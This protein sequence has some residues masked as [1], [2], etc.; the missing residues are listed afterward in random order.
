MNDYYSCLLAVP[1]E[2][3]QDFQQAYIDAAHNN[4][5]GVGLEANN[6]GYPYVYLK[7]NGVAI[8]YDQSVAQAAFTAS[9]I[10]PMEVD[11]PD[12]F[13]DTQIKHAGD[14]LY[15]DFTDV[16]KYPQY[17]VS[18]VGELEY[19]TMG[20]SREIDKEDKSKYIDL[21]HNATTFCTPGPDSLGYSMIQMDEV[22][23]NN[24]EGLIVSEVNRFNDEYGNVIERNG[25][26]FGEDAEHDGWVCAPEVFNAFKAECIFRLAA[27]EYVRTLDDAYYW[28]DMTDVKINTDGLD[29]Q[30]LNM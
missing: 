11:T 6:Y 2:Q 20:K 29:D 4:G 5:Y 26:H 17:S 12:D 30:Q 27:G 1:D 28:E 15:L 22:N 21:M 16:D 25:D 24:D 13:V 7:D 23:N 9:G 10:K 14:K 8:P 3:R 18:G 19:A